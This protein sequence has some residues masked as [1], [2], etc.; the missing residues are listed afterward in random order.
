ML[1]FEGLLTWA[2]RYPVNYKLMATKLLDRF[3][4][5]T[6]I[7]HQYRLITGRTEDQGT[8]FKTA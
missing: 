1:L 6:Q 2:Y 4:I 7:P 8:S 3:C 5:S